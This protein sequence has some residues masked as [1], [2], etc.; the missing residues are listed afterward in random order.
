MKRDLKISPN[1]FILSYFHLNYV[2]MI[3]AP[4]VY[5]KCLTNY[6]HAV[7]S[8]P[9]YLAYIHISSNVLRFDSFYQ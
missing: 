9:K 6:V 2:H 1:W 3:S 7:P 8:L 4:S 5:R